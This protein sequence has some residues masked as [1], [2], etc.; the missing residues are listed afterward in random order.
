MNTFRL[1]KCRAHSLFLPSSLS[2]YAPTAANTHLL[3]PISRVHFWRGQP[4]RSRSHRICDALW[5][6]LSRVSDAQ[7]DH[8]RVWMGFK[9]L[10]TTASNLGKKVSSCELCQIGITLQPQDGVGACSSTR[11]RSCTANRLRPACLRSKERRPTLHQPR[12]HWSEVEWSGVKWSGESSD[13]ICS[14]QGQR[15]GQ[16]ICI[17]VC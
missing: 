10:S 2:P 14:R 13:P 5:D 4:S 12:S 3:C 15:L 9:V 8:R 1:G 7:A 17:H 6:R 16:A 11:R